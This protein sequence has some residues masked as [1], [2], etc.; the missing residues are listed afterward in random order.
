[1]IP[2]DQQKNYDL[3][4]D[5]LSSVLIDRVTKPE[6]KA[7]RRAKSK[8]SR[9]QTSVIS[10]TTQEEESN[11]LQD[12]EELGDFVEYIA[13]ETFESLPEELKTIEHHD[14]AQDTDL[15]ARYSL[16]L[17]GDDVGTLIPALDPSV[18]E[19][20]LT[21]GIADKGRGQG[22]PEF[23]APVLTAFI[24]AIAAPPPAPSSTRTTACEICGRDWIPLT[25]H[26]LIPRFVHAK[27][28]KRGWHREDD[29][30]NVAWL[31]RACHSFVHKFASHEDLA[32]YHYTVDLLLEQ[33][34]I[35]QFAKWVSRL[36]W[37][38]R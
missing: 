25:Y 6:P 13:A 26:H 36:R 14:Y 7:R 2:D 35:V 28:V 38:G 5:C 37:K 20:L 16:P 18:S 9:E 34:E 27:A 32:R 31:C 1:M 29:L 4:R 15:Q 23:L 8:K 19:S 33:D 30:Q 3:F 24:S 22:A 12:T 10:S 17:T 21:Y 11:K